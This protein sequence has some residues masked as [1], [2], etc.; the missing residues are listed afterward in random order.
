MKD[1][2]LYKVAKME[3]NAA[4]ITLVERP[5]TICYLEAEN[6]V[7]HLFLE[8]DTRFTISAMLHELEDLIPQSTFF[9]CGKS[10][11]VNA[12]KVLEYWV[13]SDPI[14][15][16]SC[17]HIVPV[18]KTEMHQVQLS[19]KLKSEGLENKPKVVTHF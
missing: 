7:T 14:L 4:V 12:E 9:Y 19:L 17:G 10:Y 13:S 3:H 6:M 18:P 8:N 15:V 5:Q 1:S 16:M 2:F 11:M